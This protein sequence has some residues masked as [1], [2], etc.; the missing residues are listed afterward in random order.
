MTRRL[1]IMAGKG[2]LPMLLANAAREAGWSVQFLSFID[3]LELDKADYGKV[4]P[5]K[6][7]AMVLAVRRTKAS[8][9]CLAGG[10]DL[11]D[12]GRDG[13]AK[14]FSRGK[15]KTK[16][17]GDAGLAKM[18]R[19]LEIATGAKL[20][21]AHEIMPDLLAGNGHIAGPKIKKP[22]ID[23]GIFALSTAIAA[24]SLDLGQA[25]VCAGHRVIAVE[26]IAGTDALLER[27]K[28]FRE[29]SLVGDGSA[30]LILSKAKKPEQPMFADLPAIGPDTILTAHA[31]G[32][33]AIFV[34]AGRSIIIE[35]DKLK[36]RAEELGIT[37]F[38]ATADE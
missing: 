13:L 11:S 10:V 34:E 32:I 21:G 37:V 9:L 28:G 16:R 3:R 1:T 36:Q 7:V 8:H 35:R 33:S 24:G 23:D 2:A 6:P 14:F 38:G 18:G 27:V 31:A 22:L 30:D 17:T 5:S 12:K 15:R 19:A 25:V 29:A 26:D 4:D 20:I